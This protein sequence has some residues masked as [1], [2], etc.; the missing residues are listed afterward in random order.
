MSEA[1]MAKIFDPYFTTKEKGVGTGLG[2]AVVHGIVQKHGGAVRV[3]SKLGK[4][5]AFDL[6]FPAIRR[7]VFPQTRFQEKLPTGHEHILLIDDEQVLVDM[8]KE[9]LEHL[10]YSVETR[11]GSVDALDLFSAAP[12]RFDLVISDLTMPN[13]TGD[14]LAME[15]MRIRADIPVIVCTGYSERLVE[16]KIKEVGIR[17]FIMKPILMSRMAKVIR[18]VLDPK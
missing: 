11:T 10:G 13:M 12:S 8:G 3:Q 1:T 16:E 17:A 14:K 4:G 18:E 2:L 6:Y 5:S 15:L 9:M 7:E